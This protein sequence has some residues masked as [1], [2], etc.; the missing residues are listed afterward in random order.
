MIRKAFRSSRKQG[1]HLQENKFQKNHP[2]EEETE[3]FRC[4]DSKPSR[5]ANLHVY[6][7]RVLV[8]ALLTQQS[9]SLQKVLLLDL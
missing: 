5:D 1:F 9:L 6:P 3:I 7:C 2:P 4:P 8:L